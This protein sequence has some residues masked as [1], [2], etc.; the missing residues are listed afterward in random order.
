M[1]NSIDFDKSS[2]LLRDVNL[3]SQMIPADRTPSIG[4]LQ[5]SRFA[6]S[7]RCKFM[8]A[9]FRPLEVLSRKRALM[10]K[11]KYAFALDDNVFPDNASTGFD[12][13]WSVMALEQRKPLRNLERIKSVDSELHRNIEFPA[14]KKYKLPRRNIF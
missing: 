2:T 11:N 3:G 7:P 5:T 13:R 14:R 8:I 10:Q 9:K 12:E 6:M 4:K 1:P